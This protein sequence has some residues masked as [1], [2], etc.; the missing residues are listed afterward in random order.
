[1][2]VMTKGGQ[3]TEAVRRR[4]YS[5]ILFDEIE[6]AHS[7]VFNILLQ[8]LDEGHLTDSKGTHCRFQK[9]SNHNDFQYW[10][11]IY[12]GLPSKVCCGGRCQLSSYERTRSGSLERTFP[13]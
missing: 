11:P 5:C 1:M 3:L 12:P 4:A 8:V 7:D 2:S 6:K 13:S 10:Q 9:Y